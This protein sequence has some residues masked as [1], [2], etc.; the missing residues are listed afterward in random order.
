MQVFIVMIETSI[1][2]TYQWAVHRVFA[3]KKSAIEYIEHAKQ[4]LYRDVEF[5]I[6][7][8]TVH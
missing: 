4:G 8:W 1:E 7:A 5:D 6:E 3:T 2:C